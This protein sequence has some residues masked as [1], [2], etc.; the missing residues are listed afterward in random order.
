[1]DENRG[2]SIRISRSGRVHDVVMNRAIGFVAL[3]KA[4]AEIL[5]VVQNDDTKRKMTR[6]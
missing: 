4:T 3:Q 2:G 1:M 5:D 6:E